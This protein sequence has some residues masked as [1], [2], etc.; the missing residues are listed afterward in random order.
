MAADQRLD[1]VLRDDALIGAVATHRAATPGL[2]GA[3]TVAVA[4]ALMGHA[5][6]GVGEAGD[7]AGD[8]PSMRAELSG[9]TLAGPPLGYIELAEPAV[10]L[11]ARRRQHGWLL[12]ALG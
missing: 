12:T 1:R 3:S 6:A 4:L 5:P 10:A 2:L 11:A 9:R 8:L 7:G